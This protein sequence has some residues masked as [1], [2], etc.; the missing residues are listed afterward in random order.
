MH[1]NH[2]K[3]DMSKLELDSDDEQESVNIRYG[4]IQIEDMMRDL[5]HWETLLSSSFMQRPHTI[6]QHGDQYDEIMNL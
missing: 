2:C 3:I 4:I 1:F 6:I 5:Q